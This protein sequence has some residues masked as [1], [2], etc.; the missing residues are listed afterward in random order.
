M[1]I[2]IV[3]AYRYGYRDAHSYVVGAY[4]SEE[5]ASVVTRPID[6]LLSGRI[7]F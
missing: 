7:S 3:V 5:I 4:P 1:N 2:W 6:P